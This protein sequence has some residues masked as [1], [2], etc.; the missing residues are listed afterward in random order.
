M[1]PVVSIGLADNVTDPKATFV[2][3]TVQGGLAPAEAGC[4][5]QQANG[6]HAAAISFR[7][8][9]GCTGSFPMECPR[10]RPWPFASDQDRWLTAAPRTHANF[11]DM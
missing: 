5:K 7:I 1:V 10:L 4:A 9:L 8:S 11:K 2:M 3:D 6:K